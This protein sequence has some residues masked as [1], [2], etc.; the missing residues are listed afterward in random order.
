MIP[1]YLLATGRDISGGRRQ[2]RKNLFG[3]ALLRK[4]G[5]SG[6]SELASYALAAAIP[7]F[8][9][10]GGPRGLSVCKLPSFCMVL[11]GASRAY[12]ACCRK[13]FW[14]AGLCLSTQSQTVQENVLVLCHIR[15]IALDGKRF[16]SPHAACGMRPG[17]SLPIP[18]IP[19]YSIPNSE[20]PYTNA[21]NRIH[22]TQGV[23]AC[24][25]GHRLKRSVSSDDAILPSLHPL[26][27]TE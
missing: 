4:P 7:F 8:F 14:S 9:F 22:S 26:S 20:R 12:S 6:V 23:L 17:E 15:V 19:S 13:V 16:S 10:G 2:N 11:Y 21:I 27:I 1:L 24:S 25:E 5:L 3:A 18:L